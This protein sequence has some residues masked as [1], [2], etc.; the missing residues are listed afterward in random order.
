M[1]EFADK[2]SQGLTSA[3]NSQPSHQLTTRPFVVRATSSDHAPL[4]DAQERHYLQQLD[5]GVMQA[6]QVDTLPSRVRGLPPIQRQSGLDAASPAPPSALD[7]KVQQDA[8]DLKKEIVSK[9]DEIIAAAERIDQRVQK[10]LKARALETPNSDTQ[11]PFPA[12]GNEKIEIDQLINLMVKNHNNAVIKAVEA[13]FSMSLAE[14]EQKKYQV[15]AAEVI[16]ALKANNSYSEAEW[17]AWAGNKT[18]TWDENHPLFEVW[19]FAITTL[20][21]TT[22]QGIWQDAYWFKDRQRTI[23]EKTGF[24]LTLKRQGEQDLVLGFDP[25][26][27]ETKTPMDLSKPQNVEKGAHKGY[28]FTSAQG[29]RCIVWITGAEGFVES[30]ITIDGKRIKVSGGRWGSGRWQYE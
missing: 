20:P 25:K 8:D 5:A 30:L 13:H 10:A 27:D 28:P 2:H 24:N 26:S 11:L 4:T 12:R 9:L 19:K 6:L 17:N 22:Y 15:T 29:H 14:S 3:S 1:N 18:G 16:T 23:L 7:P 21:V